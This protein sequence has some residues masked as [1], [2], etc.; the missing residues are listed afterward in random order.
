MKR[1]LILG[2]GGFAGRRLAGALLRH[3]EL[4]LR[5]LVRSK[6]KA[7]LPGGIELFEGDLLRPETL[8]PAFEGVDTA[9]CLVHSMAGPKGHF[10][11][12]DRRAAVIIGAGGA[13]FEIIRA[14]VKR[15]PLMVTPLWVDTRCQPI[16]IAD[17]IRYLQGCLFEEATAGGTFDIGGEEILSY[18]QMMERFARLCGEV[19]LFVPVPVMTPR[20]SSYWV[21][22]V[23]PVQPAG[24]RTAPRPGAPG[25]LHRAGLCP[26][27]LARLPAPGQEPKRLGGLSRLSQAA[28]S[29]P[30]SGP[31]QGDGASGGGGGEAGDGPAL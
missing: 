25:E 8:G 4:E 11:E 1:V 29:L 18:R 15:L 6:Q 16:A 10:A 9:Y 23:T 22:L 24:G 21:G 17:V 27:A 12:S 30:Q 7:A 14:L 26:Q 20:L 2:A 3:G 19:N 5:A 31:G 28:A 13:S